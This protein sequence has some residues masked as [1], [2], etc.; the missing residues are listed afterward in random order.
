VNSWYTGP[1][2]ECTQA[3]GGGKQKRR[4]YC[5]MKISHSKEK[6]VRRNRC[7]HLKKPA[8]KIPCNTQECP[9]SWHAKEW[10]QVGSA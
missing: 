8:R 7:S 3:C 4:V 10:S 1:W 6:R 2:T 5:S 9:P